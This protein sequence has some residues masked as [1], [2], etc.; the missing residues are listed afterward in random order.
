MDVSWTLRFNGHGFDTVPGSCV[1]GY[2]GY[3]V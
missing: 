1:L 3:G 2:P